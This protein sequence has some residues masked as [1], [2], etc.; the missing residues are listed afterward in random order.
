MYS[1]PPP[2]RVPQA[3]GV[4]CPANI[5]HG[6]A[7][8]PRS[9]ADTLRSAADMLRGADDTPRIGVDTA[10]FSAF[11]GAK[12]HFFQKVLKKWSSIQKK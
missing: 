11:L 12:K 9:A 8:T 7:D 6:A 3:P 5:P 4:S 10:T 1:T 2:P